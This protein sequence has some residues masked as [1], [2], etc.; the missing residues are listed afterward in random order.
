MAKIYALYL[1]QFYRTPE[2]DEWWGEGFTDWVTVQSA[3]PLFEGHE[4]PN[5]PL[6]YYNLLEKKTMQKQAELMHEYGIDGLC[7]YHYYFESGRKILEKPAENLLKWEDIDMP[8]CFYWANQSWA[9]TWSNLQGA[10]V[11]TYTQNQYDRVEDNDGILL[12]QSYGGE[13]EWIEHLEYLLPF[14]LDDRYIKIQD[15]PLFIIYMPE[16]IKCFQEMKKC[17]DNIMDEKGLPHVFFMGKN[18]YADGFDGYMDHEPQ[19]VFSELG[20]QKYHNDFGI[21]DIFNYDDVWKRILENPEVGDNYF[22]GGFVGF[23]DTPRHGKRGRV[24][25]GRSPRKFRKYLIQL[26]IKANRSNNNV[27][28][29]NAWNEWG[30]GMYLEPDLKNGDAY[31]QAVKDAKIFVENNDDILNDLFE[32]ND[33]DIKKRGAIKLDGLI[34][35]NERY[36]NY[37]MIFRDFLNLLIE[38]KKISKYLND[39]NID[40]VAIYGMGMIGSALYKELCNERRKISFAIDQDYSKKAKFD[41]PIFTL[42]ESF[43]SIDLVIVAVGYG[44]EEI[45]KILSTK[46]VKTIISI[47]EMIDYANSS[48]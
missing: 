32:S 44:Y 19:F 25:V 8:F 11:W 17:W 38:G 4:Q 9:K 45:K 34:K 24:V 3:Q 46:G 14:F 40:T 30:E 18:T 16:D 28:F 29:L 43:P 26:L 6:E 20:D 15:R 27:I 21:K 47:D 39:N 2:N 33:S 37:W 12:N 48:K 22:Y 1:P 7:F 23:D 42:Q 5:E 13:K 35:K 10:N 31:L 41:I 36:R